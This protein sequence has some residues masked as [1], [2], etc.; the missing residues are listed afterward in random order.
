MILE[1]LTLRNFRVFEGEQSFDLKPRVKYNKRRPIILF[2]GLNGAGKT[3]ILT[4]A[5]LALYGRLSLGMHVSKRE[6]DAFLEKCVHRSR[7]EVTQPDF[8][9]VELAFSYASM[10]I[11]KNY[12]AKRH[13]R[14]SHGGVREEL[15]IFED[16]ELIQDMTGEHCQ[17]FLNELVPIGVSELFFFDGEKISELAEDRNGEALG[18]AIKKLLGLDVI[19]TLNADLGILLRNQSKSEASEESCQRLSEMESQLDELDRSATE[20]LSHYEQLKPEELELSEKISRLE[21]QLSARGGAWAA[22]RDE[23]IRREGELNAEKRQLEKSIREIL[24]SE[25][26]LAL[27]PGLAKRALDQ[28]RLE[29]GQ[30]AKLAA[31]RIAAEHFSTLDSELAKIL[32]KSELQKVRTVIEA[33]FAELLSAEKGIKL[34]HGVSERA[35]SAIENALHTAQKSL[36]KKAKALAKRLDEVDEKLDAAGKNIARAPATEQIQPLLHQIANAHEA[37]AACKA[38]QRGHVEEHKRLLRDALA[39][40]RKLEQASSRIISGEEKN[41]TARYANSTRALLKDFSAEM[42]MRKVRDLEGEFL[43]SFQRLIR[44]G[45][46]DYV[47]SIDPS[48]FSVKL[49][50]KDGTEVDK[51]ELSAGEKQI[52]AISI[53]EALARTSG[54]HLPIIIDTPLGRLDSVHR[55]KLVDNYFPT[56]SHQVIILSTDTEVDEAFYEDLS[57]NISHA[58]K[59]D[60]DQK[61][62][63]TV[64]QEGYFWKQ[65]RQNLQGAS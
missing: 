53:L 50:N 21:A 26:P 32:K 22:T 41:R 38:K 51:S 10:G 8:A 29:A 12:T 33:E 40:A 52:Y 42:A 46:V 36:K 7:Q 63:R 25:Y 11:V 2:G 18:E 23:E 57:T 13:W 65:K 9:E 47:A 19:E 16:G 24:E 59:L 45:D 48:S 56:A 14:V 49:L 43:Q 1:R 39:M 30:V 5:R 60:Y 6:Y 54:R 34:V 28:L 4:A 15:S 17:G 35:S 58:F 64:A 3:T 62:S 61:A 27:A 37:L 20:A 31:G 44:K 55:S